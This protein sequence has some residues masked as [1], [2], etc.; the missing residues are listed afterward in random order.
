MF[1]LVRSLSLEELEVSRATV[2]DRFTDHS[3]LSN[4]SLHQENYGRMGGTI[5]IVK[6]A[7]CVARLQD[8]TALHLFETVFLFFSSRSVLFSRLVSLFI[9]FY[10]MTAFSVFPFEVAAPEREA[11]GK[12]TKPASLCVHSPRTPRTLELSLERW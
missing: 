10:P 5:R 12:P 1:N 6:L 9:Q 3:T 7:R 2:A 4:V 8:L 11:G